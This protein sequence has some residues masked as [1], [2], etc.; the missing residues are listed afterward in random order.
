MKE[1]IRKSLEQAIKELQSSRDW[2]DF[3]LSEINVERPKGEAFGDYTTNIA[4][5]LAKSVGKNPL[6]IADQIVE[7]INGQKNESLEKIEIVK[8]GYINFYLSEK[9]FQELIQAVIDK[10]ADFGS[11]EKKKEKIMVEYS[12]PN[13]LKEFHIGHLRN[14]FIG[15][16]LVNVLR[17][18]GYD[19]TAANYIGD[20]GTHIAKCLWGILKFHPD[21]DWDKVENKT[22]FLGTIYSEAVQKIESDPKLENEFRETQKKLAEKE[23]ELM[24][25]WEK[26]RQWSLDDFSKIYDRLGTKFDVYFYESEEEESGKKMVESLIEKGIARES[27]GAVIAD[28]EKYDL[29]VL[30]LQRNDGSVLYGLKDIP[31]AIKKFDQYKID[32]SIVVVDIRQSLYFRQLVKILEIYGINKSTEH[33]GYEFVMLKGG[34]SMSSRKGNV[35][36]GRKLLDLIISEVGKKFPET[37]EAEKIG[38]AA[39][40]FFM[41]KYGA[42]TKIEFDIDEAVKLEGATG[43]YVQYAQVRIRSIMRIAEEFFSDNQKNSADLTLLTHEKE[44]SLIR[45]LDRFGELI[46]EVSKTYEVSRFPYYAIRLADKFHSFYNDCQVLDPKNPEL[47][48]AR[49]KLV[50]AVRIVLGETLRIINVEAPERM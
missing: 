50:E 16:S 30:V 11:G 15:S 28:L 22:E 41:L 8:P 19:V 7:L 33:I 46:D 24:K 2:P 48:K 27:E 44:L 18:A 21:V 39:A 13:T 3:D 20:T 9:Y 25:L 17:K 47:S 36:P 5:V 26:T 1:E 12:Q 42:A 37:V 35:I 6:D 10:Q 38:L 23:P 49:L 4:M 40:R 32:K 43:P 34:E 29:G 31:L 14:V 45:E